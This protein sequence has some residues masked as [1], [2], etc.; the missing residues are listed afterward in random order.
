VI[1]AGT[2][3]NAGGTWEGTSTGVMGDPSG[4]DVIT[5]WMRGTGDYAGLSYTCRVTGSGP[6]EVTGY[7]F[8]GD[9]PAASLPAPAGG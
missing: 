1:G 2:I 9:P 6:W 7:I 8:S 3:T 5:F 4:G